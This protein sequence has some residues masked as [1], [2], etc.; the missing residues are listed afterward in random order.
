MKPKIK[1]FNDKKLK[2]KPQYIRRAKS[3]ERKL[4]SFKKNHLKKANINI[5]LLKK[6]FFKMKNS[7]TNFKRR[8]QFNL[9]TSKRK[10]NVSLD[11]IKSRIK[12]SSQYRSSQKSKYT[13]LRLKKHFRK[14]YLSQDHHK[15]NYNSQKKK[16]QRKNKK[17]SKS[18][19][20]N[21]MKKSKNQ[22][23]PL[24]NK[25]NRKNNQLCKNKQIQVSW[26]S[27]P[28]TYLESFKDQ[29]ILNKLKNEQSFPKKNIC[30]SKRECGVSINQTQ[31][32]NEI[33][34]TSL[35]KIKNFASLRKGI[36]KDKTPQ[37][38]HQMFIGMSDQFSQSWRNKLKSRD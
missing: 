26:I 18:K 11:K 7:K 19:V 8:N 9:Q 24:K 27:N 15:N 34:A 10:K 12:N 29:L 25:N 21:K 33:I 14:K 20:K 23:A 37:G 30:F 6:Q 4:T 17:T 1:H 31:K 32:V 22:L 38:F 2:L 35:P 28:K 36:S 3:T 13:D 5:D 16:I